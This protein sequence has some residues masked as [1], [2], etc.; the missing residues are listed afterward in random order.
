MVDHEGVAAVIE[1][2]V[3]LLVHK[4]VGFARLGAVW[5]GEIGEVEALRP[6][7]IAAD[8][9]LAVGVGDAED[10]VI[11]AQ[12]AVDAAHQL[13]GSRFVAVVVRAAALIRAKTPV[14]APAQDF[15]AFLAGSGFHLSRKNTVKTYLSFFRLLLAFY[16]DR[17][18]ETLVK[19]DL[20]AFLLHGVSKRKWSESAQNQAV[21]AVKYYYEKVLGQERTYYEL[22]PRK[23][24]K[25]PNVFSEEEVTQLLQGVK[26]LK[27][28]TILTLIYSAGL[29]IGE[30]VRMRKA[31]ICLSRK[32]VFVKA[33]KGKKDRYTV[34]SDKMAALLTEYLAVYRPA[35]WLFEGQD[36]GQYSPRSIQQ[37]FRRAVA[38]A[39]VNPYSTVHTLRHSFATH[40]LEPRPRKTWTRELT[41]G[42]SK[43]CSAIAAARP[44][45][46][47]PMSPKK[48]AR[49]FVVR[50]IFWIFSSKQ[51]KAMC[52]SLFNL[53]VC[54]QPMIGSGL[55]LEKR[56][57]SE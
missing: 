48:R 30:C 11:F 52:H 35:Y 23:S 25:L 47:I 22:R 39:E 21:N 20:M 13:A 42:I 6:Q 31:D 14:D 33:G 10:A 17:H 19:D 45:R 36:G 57:W 27:H 51:Q 26:N 9:G 55:F 50:W 54:C 24:K 56:A 32:S 18:P 43:A 37:V 2:K 8:A 44:R 12:C 1:G 34:L 40:L 46:F 16:P 5:V 7:E 41:C 29:R 49:S 15:A 38:K 28:R 53:S 3:A 4:I